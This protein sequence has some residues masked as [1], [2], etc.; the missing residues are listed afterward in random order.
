MFIIQQNYGPGYVAT[1]L[2]SGLPGYGS[3]L[4]HQGTAGLVPVAT[5]SWASIL[6]VARFF[7]F[8]PQPPLHRGPNKNPPGA[9]RVPHHVGPQAPHGAALRSE[10]RHGQRA[11]L[12]RGAAAA[13]RQA[14]GRKIR[15]AVVKTVVDPMLVGI[16]E[17]TTQLLE[18]I[19]VVGLVDVHWGYD[20]AFDPGPFCF[21]FYPGFGVF[22]N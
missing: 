19:L 16:G 14:P 10:L 15:K 18:P 1:C 17:F 13:E 22:G 6:G 9:A 5:Y 7:F 8:A 20:L 2:S 21:R 3:K 12:R 4:T 11:L